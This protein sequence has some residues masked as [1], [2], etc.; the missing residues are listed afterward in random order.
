[1]NSIHTSHFPAYSSYLGFRE[2]PGFFLFNEHIQ[3]SLKFFF[4][5]Y[6]SIEGKGKCSYSRL[7]FGKSLWSVF[8]CS[9]LPFRS[10]RNLNT[11]QSFQIGTELIRHFLA[12]FQHSGL[13]LDLSDSQRKLGNHFLN[14]GQFLPASLNGYAPSGGIYQDR[15]FRK[16]FHSAS[17]KENP[18]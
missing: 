11:R 18:A 5:G 1:M 15:G 7:D 16:H 2:K 8:K 14:L 10:H 3:N 13:N 12:N 6:Q 17:Q 4:A 9:P